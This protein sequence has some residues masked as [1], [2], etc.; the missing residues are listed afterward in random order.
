MHHITKNF[1][2]PGLTR[3]PVNKDTPSY[4]PPQKGE[5]DTGIRRNDGAFKSD[6]LNRVFLILR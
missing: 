6:V 1:V 2:M 4:L 5:G 3:H